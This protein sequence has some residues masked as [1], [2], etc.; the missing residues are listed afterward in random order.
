MGQ[1]YAL[2][3]IEHNTLDE[4][5]NDT[6]YANSPLLHSRLFGINGGDNYTCYIS[7]LSLYLTLLWSMRSNSMMPS[8]QS[9][10]ISFIAYFFYRPSIAKVK[11]L[12]EIPWCLKDTDQNYSLKR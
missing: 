12:L 9:G 6:F 8:S 7:L 3:R 11:C 4:G 2:M 10:Q 1:D 5:L